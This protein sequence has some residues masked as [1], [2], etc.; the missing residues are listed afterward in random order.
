[1]ELQQRFRDGMSQLAGAV[2][3]VATDG[4]HGRGGITATAVCS[5]SDAPPTLLVC[6]NSG[7]DLNPLL[8]AN[9]HFSVN[10]LGAGHEG[11]SNRFA[12]YVKGVSMAERLLEGDWAPGGT[13]SPL[14]RDALASFDCR[15]QGFQEVGTHT[16]MF[17]EVQA[18]WLQGEGKPLLYFRRAYGT[19][20]G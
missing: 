5:V 7:S 18:V 4:P 1:M 9:Q 8:K 20:G 11:L 19:V 2:T 3:I 17:G 15:L 10:V 6:V 12:G 16:V 13:G 14:L